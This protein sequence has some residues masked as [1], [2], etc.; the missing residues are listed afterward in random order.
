MR[1]SYGYAGVKD[2]FENEAA[3]AGTG[4]WKMNLETGERTLLFSLADLAKIPTFG[5]TPEV[6]GRH[7]V[8]HFG[9]APGG[10]RFLCLNRSGD[11]KKIDRMFTA[12]A[13]G[14]NIRFIHHLPSHFCWRDDE[15]ICGWSR[16]AYRLFKADGS[17]GPDGKILYKA[18]NGHQ[19][20]LK[21]GE[22]MITDTYP[23]KADRNQY[24]YLVHLPDMKF[25]VIGIFHEDLRYD[26]KTKG[27]QMWRC[28]R[29]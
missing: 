13:N 9:W 2:P 17:D 12:D 8:N 15:T 28:R 22:W 10:K 6:Q 27:E 7:Y 20:F 19:T 29:P 21:G 18:P 5:Y 25:T 24:L 14:K 4:A 3:P 23:Q 11:T 16:D 26:E 1:A